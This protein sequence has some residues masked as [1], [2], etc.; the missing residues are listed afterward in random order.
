MSAT[1]NS[2]PGN[3]DAEHA[4][5]SGALTNPEVFHANS[6]LP[7]SAFSEP[8]HGRIWGHIGEAVGASGR[9][10]FMLIAE[11]MKDDDALRE[12]GGAAF[13]VNLW[14]MPRTRAVAQYGDL[15]GE[16]ASLRSLAQLGGELTARAKSP[17]GA[18]SDEILAETEAALAE[19]AE[20]GS[21][22]SDWHSAADVTLAAIDTARSR[23]SAPQFPSGLTELDDMTGGFAPGELAVIAGRPGMGKS[24]GALAIAKANARAGRGSLLYSLEMSREAVGLRLACD[25]AYDPDA[26]S[27]GGR[28]ENP[29]FD[30]AR[31]NVLMAD[32]WSRLRE[33]ACATADWPLQI[34][35]RPSLSVAQMEAGARRQFR[36]WARRGVKPGPVIVDHLGI[37]R[38]DKARGGNKV[39]ETGD[40]S[41]GLA[42]MAKRLNVPVVALCQI[43]RTSEGRDD[44]RPS[45]A[46]LRWS[47]AIE[48]DARLVIFLHRPAYFLR[49]PED[50]S[51]ESPPQRIEREAKLA[52]VRHKLLWIIAK[53]NNGPTGQVETFCDI[54]CSAIRDRRGFR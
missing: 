38:P 31:R 48:E 33:A 9:A 15:I 5:L 30:R 44:K 23:D 41:R 52:D 12:A 16:L 26:V 18:T 17:Q 35:D 24:V 2:L 8:L 40:V 50:P 3:L 34:D 28:G 43:N 21:S 6:D 53:Q 37:I 14:D 27:Y 54:G 49:P 45:L 10:D 32:Q 11:R 29:T 46:E 39:Q 25:L 7:P 19:I 1:A 4:L 42:E 47:G 51:Q 36:E 20:T 13:I 22:K